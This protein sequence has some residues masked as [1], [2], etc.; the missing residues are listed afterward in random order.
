MGSQQT[1]HVLMSRI[2]GREQRRHVFFFLSLHGFRRIW[3]ENKWE[4]YKGEDAVFKATC[5]KT[6]MDVYLPYVAALLDAERKYVAFF[7]FFVR[8]AF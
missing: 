8:N 4:R 7:A 1:G 3:E 2:L 6:L 5:K